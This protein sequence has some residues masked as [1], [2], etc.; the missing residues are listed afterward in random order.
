MFKI[1]S[2]YPTYFAKVTF[3][4]SLP[5]NNLLFVSFAKLFGICRQRISGEIPHCVF[6]IQLSVVIFI[7]KVVDNQKQNTNG[8]NNKIDDG[9]K[10]AHACGHF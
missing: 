8:A 7:A 10:S 4:L 5:K 3:F 2:I 9:A 1:L 6:S